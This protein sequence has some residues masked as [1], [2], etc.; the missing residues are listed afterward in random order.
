MVFVSTKW[1]ASIIGGKGSTTEFIAS[2]C[3]V[4]K[5]LLGNGLHG[6]TSGAEDHFPDKLFKIS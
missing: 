2:P 1:G 4:R 5:S 3:G 6:K